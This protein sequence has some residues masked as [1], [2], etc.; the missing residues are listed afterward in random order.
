MM[1]T[2]EVVGKL[3]EVF[4]NDTFSPFHIRRNPVVRQVPDKNI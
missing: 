1:D 2:L 4:K 3:S